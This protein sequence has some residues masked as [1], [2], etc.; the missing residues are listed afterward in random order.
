MTPEIAFVLLTVGVMIIGLITEIARPYIVVFSTLVVFLISGILTPDEAV[1]GFSNQGMLTLALLFIIAGTIQQSG[2]LDQLLKRFL[3]A[4]DSERKTM[5]KILFP[6][7]GLSAFLNNTPIVI[8]FT[9]IIR[10][11]CM[12]NNLLPSKFLIPLSYAT[13]LGGTIT[14]MGTSTNLLVHS[15][16]IDYQIGSLSLFQLSIIGVPITIV[17]IFYLVT[18]GHR[19]LPENRILTETVI[20]QCR[21]YIGEVV[22]KE[23]FAFI[24]KTIKDAGLRNLNGIYLVSIFRE[25]E[26]ITP[27][28]R[29]TKI[30]E[31]DRLIFAGV[32]SSIVELQHMKGLQLETHSG[33]DIEKILTKHSTLVEVV[34]SHQSS[35]LH[36]RIKTTQFRERYDAAVIAVH[37]NNV[38]INSK[39]GNIIL[40]PGDTLLMI[41]GPDFKN[42]ND[43][44]DFYVI[45]PVETAEFSSKT[46]RRK[47]W[48]SSLA[49]LVLVSLVS[50]R[51][52]SMFEGVTIVTLF[53]LLFRIVTPEEAKGYIKFDVLIL[54]ACSIGIGSAL[55]KTGAAEL[56]AYGIVFFVK[57]LGLIAIMAA[58]YLITNIFTEL[59]T[60]NA[61]AVMMFPIALKVAEQ[62]SVTPT[63]FAIIVAIA[64][65]A[66]FS[67][68]IGY[69]TNLIVYGPGGYRFTDYLKVGIPLNLLV[70][71][72]TI[73]I[74]KL[75]WI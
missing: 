60:N 59:I 47:G 8:A 33:L 68:P 57:P 45:T 12:E 72:M 62:V 34:V 43:Y 69:Q 10:K 32:I 44:Q 50:I 74:L 7:S 56:I 73:F 22:V 19:L 51:L 63:A 58:V 6:L 52:V 30:K 55:L 31:G 5:L 46:T 27:V 13:I 28:K 2:I 25:Q 39:I 14:L 49:L 66:S 70:M 67:T 41:V 65:S 11:W 53:L 24:N 40:K 75:T 4:K 38:R 26:T 23:D 3:K 61:A 64:A 42:K 20:E 17:G 9:P 29:S 35:F 54:I 37:R 16:M 36:K 71:A 48:I 21:E 18:F 1:K 15:L